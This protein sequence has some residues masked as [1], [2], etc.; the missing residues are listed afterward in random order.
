MGLLKLLLAPVTLPASGLGFVL[1]EV[2]DAA[3]REMNDPDAI[4]REM[5]EQ[6]RRLNAGLI[7]ETAY[8]A[9][10]AELLARLNAIAGRRGAGE[11]PGGTG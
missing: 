9:A 7:D 10:E 6:Q 4:R 11:V 2:R 8:E 5:L 1:R 3:E